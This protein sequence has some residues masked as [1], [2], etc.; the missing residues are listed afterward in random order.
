M[1]KLQLNLLVKQYDCTMKKLKKLTKKSHDM[2]FLIRACR[3][4]QVH[5]EKLL[6]VQC[7]QVRYA[8]IELITALR[9]KKCIFSKKCLI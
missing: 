3:K 8:N 7:N 1:D 2:L 5:S 9:K 4:F 6:P